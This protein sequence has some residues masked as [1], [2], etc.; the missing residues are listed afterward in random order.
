M[1]ACASQLGLLGCYYRSIF[2]GYILKAQSVPVLEQER[3][4]PENGSVLP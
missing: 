2:T 3:V 4:D 1:S